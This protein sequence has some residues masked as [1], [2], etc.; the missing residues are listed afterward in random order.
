VDVRRAETALDIQ[1][2]VDKALANAE[3]VDIGLKTAAH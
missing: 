1:A 3:M 2:L